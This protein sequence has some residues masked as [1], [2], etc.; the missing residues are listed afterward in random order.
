MSKKEKLL[1]YAVS[2]PN[3]LSFNEFCTLMKHQGW[4][5]D[6]QRGS[7]QI[8]I[9]PR[10][11]RLSVQNKDGSAKGYQVKQFLMQLNEEGIENA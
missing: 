6:H 7:H 1:Q 4:F 5:L 11:Y 3:S 8:W 10:L 2:H 9:S